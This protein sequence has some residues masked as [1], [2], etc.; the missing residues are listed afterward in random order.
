M[1]YSFHFP[2]EQ[3]SMP[4]IYGME[5]IFQVN[6]NLLNEEWSQM[7]YLW[8][9]FHDCLPLPIPVPS[10]NNIAFFIVFVLNVCIKTI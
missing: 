3:E 8:P 2:I 4:K 6:D 7:A 5:E 1:T 10:L 9:H